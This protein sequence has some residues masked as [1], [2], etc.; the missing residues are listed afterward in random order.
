MKLTAG[1]CTSNFESHFTL[2]EKKC[3]SYVREQKTSNQR[4]QNFC[5]QVF[6][7]I[8]RQGLRSSEIK[9]LQYQNQTKQIK[10]K[11]GQNTTE[12]NSPVIR[13]ITLLSDPGI[14]KTTNTKTVNNEVLL[15]CIRVQGSIPWLEKV[16]LDQ[17]KVSKLLDVEHAMQRKRCTLESAEATVTFSLFYKANIRDWNT[18]YSWLG[19]NFTRCQF[20]Q[21]FM[22]AFFCQMHFRMKNAWVKSWWN[23]WQVSISPTFYTQL[24]RS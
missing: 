5:I 13:G 7:N 18:V 21:C 16:W 12:W 10:H 3:T 22:Q 20:H 1:F 4:I 11:L 8:R 17:K 15:Y 24:L 2:Y 9:T 23:W 14:I 19:V 6:H